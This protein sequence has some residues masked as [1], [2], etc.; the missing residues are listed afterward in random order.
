MHI[1]T[2]RLIASAAALLIVLSA[3]ACDQ[4]TPAVS[5]VSTSITTPAPD[6]STVP[7]QTETTQPETT[8]T[9]APPVTTE[10]DPAV[11][12][13]ETT[14]PPQTTEESTAQP[15]VP[16]EPEF[17]NPLTGLPTATDLSGQRPAAIMINNIQVSC[18]QLGVSKADIIYECLVEGGYT[19]LMMLSLDYANLPE[20]GSVRS[21]RDYY[22]DFAADWDAIYVHAGG[23]PYAYSAIKER[24][25]NNLDGVNMYLPDTFYRN[26]ERII[27]MG[28]EHSLMTTGEKIVSG[29]KYKKYRTDMTK[30]FDYPIDF[31]K[32]GTETTF[33]DAAT[34]IHIPYSIAQITDFEYNKETGTYLRYQFNGKKHIDGATDEQL[35]FENV[36]I[37]F[38]DTGLITGDPSLRIEVGTVGEGKGYYATNGTYIPIT[39]KKDS[40]EAPIRFYTQ[41]GELL[42]MN[43]G[44]TFVSV[45]PTSSMNLISFNYKK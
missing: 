39:W 41:E 5:D 12:A 27:K 45:C 19:R 26:Q 9:T 31:V 42:L 29:I 11:S 25:V 23:S 36:L 34:Y 24:K 20:L 10:T 6:T 28:L 18:P 44:K 21:S 1:F 38:C 3:G 37:Y 22:L 30:D 32:Y 35:A 13:P 15:D 7:P 14:A 16:A 17:V 4:G 43:R 2:R 40:H 33:K 8:E